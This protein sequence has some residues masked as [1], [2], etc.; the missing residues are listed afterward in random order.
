[1]VRPH[2]H[3]DLF[4]D[5]IRLRRRARARN[6]SVPISKIVRRGVWPQ[7]TQNPHPRFHAEI[8]ELGLQSG[9]LAGEFRRPKPSAAS[10]T[11]PGIS[12]EWLFGRVPSHLQRRDR[13]GIP[14]D[15]LLLFGGATRSRFHEVRA[16]C[17]V[18]MR[19]LLGRRSHHDVHSFAFRFSPEGLPV[20][21]AILESAKGMD[22][23]GERGP[24]IPASQNPRRLHSG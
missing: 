17:R 6:G 5:R 9:V 3:G 20:T 21:S 10:S 11:F 18:A 8:T 7:K 24:S 14:P 2:G 4:A 15:S 12:D 1:V 13:S 19:K 22:R 23:G 16:E